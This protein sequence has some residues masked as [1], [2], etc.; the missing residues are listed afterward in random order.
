MEPV[1]TKIE[2][3]DIFWRKFTLPEEDRDWPWDGIG[4]RWFRSP[5][6]VPLEQYRRRRGEDKLRM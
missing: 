4:Y 1:K 6:I 5:N 3:E 2:E